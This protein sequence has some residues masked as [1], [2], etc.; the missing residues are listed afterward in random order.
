M[1]DPAACRESQGI[2]QATGDSFIVSVKLFDK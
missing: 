1:I 2:G